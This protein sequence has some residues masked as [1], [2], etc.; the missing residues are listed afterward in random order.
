MLL[1]LAVVLAPASAD[2]ATK[3]KQAHK[4][5]TSYCSIG[6]RCAYLVV[7]ASSGAVMSS[8]L[9]DKEVHPASLTKMMTLYLTFEA[10]QQGRL[11]LS[12]RVRFSQHA[13][14][15][16]PMKLGIPAGESIT[17]EDTIE[18][19]AIRSANDAAV[20]MAEKLGGSEDA[21]A[22]RMTV[23]AGQ[24][25]MSRT[26]FQ[27]ASGLPDPDQ[28]TSARDMVT[29]ARHILSDFPKYR[30]YM[31]L[32]NAMVGG[33]RI[34]GHN[35]LLTRGECEGGKTGYIN[36]SGFNIVV[37]SNRGG[38]MLVAAVF[39]GDSSGTRDQQV[40]RLLSA[41]AKGKPQ[42]PFTQPSLP[43]SVFDA[44]N[45]DDEPDLATKDMQR[46][47]VTQ[48][49]PRPVL[50]LA[51]STVPLPL[52][53]QADKDGV[54]ALIVMDSRSAPP[55]RSTPT[56][57]QSWGIQVGAYKDQLQAQQALAEATRTA[58]ALL[59]PAF[60]RTQATITTSGTLHRAQ[61]M[62]LDEKS[63]KEACAR[64]SQNGHQ[65]LTIEPSRRG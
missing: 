7:D 46:A 49:A 53:S 51:P 43:D 56:F 63:A 31:G 23:K 26:V 22:R 32:Q 6:A 3:K 52:P 20:A 1:A 12:D 13:A 36:A 64:L 57:S 21:F 11:S 10:L 47:A 45:D 59:G 65:C 9:P 55:P 50:A 4:A 44:Q 24:L 19:I 37:W 27:N 8:S 2:A 14:D 60:P 18:A 62:G 61:L 48:P 42:S 54:S 41:A 28:V 25:G 15:Q 34:T 38:R 17:V 35:R 16:S 30:G 5:P 40:V 39:G 58:P 29:L 33:K